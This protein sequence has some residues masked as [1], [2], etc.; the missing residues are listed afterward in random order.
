[1][2]TVSDSLQLI[3]C[4]G[5]CIKHHILEEAALLMRVRAALI[6]GYTEKYLENSLILSISQHNK[7]VAPLRPMADSVT[8]S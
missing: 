5:L 7:V 4:V 6:Y 8:G 2:L 1:M 3:S